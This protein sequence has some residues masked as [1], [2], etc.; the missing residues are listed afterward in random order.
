MTTVE[1]RPTHVVPP[2]GLPTWEVPDTA[3]PSAPLDALLPVQLTER[4]GDW[5]R[6]A[7]ANGWTAWVDGRLLVA[8]PQQPPDT[9]APTTHTA[10]PRPLLA[11]AQEAVT[12]YR[13]AAGEL[14]DG[15][16]DTESFHRRTRGLRVGMVVDGTSLWLYDAEHERWVYSD[17]RRLSGFA[18]DRA[19]TGDT[20]RPP[21]PAPAVGAPADRAAPDARGAGGAVERAPDPYPPTRVVTPGRE[22]E[23]PPGD[24]GAAHT[25][26]VGDPGAASTG[27]PAGREEPPTVLEPPPGPDPVPERDT[28][29][30][31]GGDSGP[32]RDADPG[33]GTAAEHRAGTRTRRL[34]RP[35]DR[36]G[37]DPR[38]GGGAP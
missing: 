26:V 4:L 13:A 37:P 5:G 16:L 36:P 27:P 1:F 19:A 25:R 6:V 20:T 30:D 21:A 38:S 34:T 28:G 2:G 18:A 35:A 9:G 33:R 11:R 7:C 15:T 24:G 8:V 23:P 10:D 32:G 22:P 12:R 3:R 31:S 14:A 17:G 29:D